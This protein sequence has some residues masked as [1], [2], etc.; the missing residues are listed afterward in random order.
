MDAVSQGDTRRY[1]ARS[2]DW[3]ASYS[4]VRYLRSGSHLVGSSARLVSVFLCT[5]D[6]LNWQCQVVQRC[7]NSDA[8]DMVQNYYV[9]MT[10]LLMGFTV[11]KIKL[12][13]FN[14]GHIRNAC[15]DDDDDKV[16]VKNRL[17]KRHKTT[18]MTNYRIGP[19]RPVSDPILTTSTRKRGAEPPE[20]MKLKF[21]C[22]NIGR[23]ISG[24][25]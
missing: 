17:I 6:C 23:T 9:I 11:S 5:M 21:H 14:V 2:T 24:T 22:M 20:S 13:L 10:V 7:N 8:C 18:G 1:S 12:V 16:K 3:L 15:D 25:V 4:A 19:H